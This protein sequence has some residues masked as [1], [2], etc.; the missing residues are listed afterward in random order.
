MTINDRARN[1]VRGIQKQKLKKSKIPHIGVKSE[2]YNF[3]RTRF[4]VTLK[5]RIKRIQRSSAT[6]IYK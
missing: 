3:F 6:G 5:Y 2:S 1:I 4:G